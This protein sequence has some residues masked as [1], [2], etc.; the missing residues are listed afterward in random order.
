MKRI[1]DISIFGEYQKKENRVTASFLQICKAGGEDLIR[2]LSN[3]LGMPLPSS[4]IDIFSQPTGEESDSV[5]DGLLKSDFSF[6]I[7][8]ESK[9]AEKS[10]NVPQ[11]NE[12]LKELKTKFDFLLY[13]T[14]DEEKPHELGENVYWANWI[15]I[16]NTFNDYLQNTQ[17]DNSQLLEFLIEHFNTLLDNLHLIGYS[18]DLDNENVIV[19]AGSFAEGVAMNYK[20]YICQN[21]RTFRPASYLA[22]YNSNQ[23]RYYFKIL[24]SPSDNV[25]LTNHPEIKTFIHTLDP[26]YAGDPQKVFKLSEPVDIGP[27]INDKIDKNGNPCPF[28]YGQPRYTKLSILQTAIRTS[29]L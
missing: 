26:E 11:L 25:V 15:N 24:E 16:I 12:H 1:E 20:Y 14:P 5:P 6:R 4:E 2:F 8:V 7:Y 22:F 21:K 3:T 23:I 18:W 19:L 17:S 9:I 10:I 13:L 28:T 29:Q 27:I